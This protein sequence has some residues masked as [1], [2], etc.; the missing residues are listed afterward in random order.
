MLNEG[1]Y[2]RDE[3]SAIG[4]TEI[5][6]DVLVSRKVSFYQLT[7][8]IG[9]NSRIDDFAIVK[10]NVEIGRFVHI[11]AYCII[12]AIQGK[13][14]FE[15]CS[16]LSSGVAVYTAS[17][18]YRAPVLNN[19]TVPEQFTKSITG[20]V[21]FGIGSLVGAH[22]V[23]LPNTIIGDGASIGAFSL[24]RGT[25]GEGDI[26]VARGAGVQVK[27]NRD[28]RIIRGLRDDLVRQTLGKLP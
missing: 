9:D 7:G 14:T 21:F 20:D 5:G 10:G 2:N 23:V 26:L 16:G 18:D 4:F 28:A 3:L 13:V 6:N 27:G 8:K 25:V 11:S 12:A 17:D 24:V 19:P 22:S 15:D 1:F